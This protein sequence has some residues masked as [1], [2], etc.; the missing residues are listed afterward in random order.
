MQLS[1][2]TRHRKMNSA[3][4]LCY[5]RP[6]QWVNAVKS[7]GTLAIMAF[8][9]KVQWL[10]RHTISKV[11]CS[12]RHCTSYRDRAGVASFI[13]MKFIVITGNS[14]K[15]MSLSPQRIGNGCTFLSLKALSLSFWSMT[16]FPKAYFRSPPHFPFN[17]QLSG[18]VTSPLPG[19]H[20]LHWTHFTCGLAWP[21]KHLS[22]STT[23]LFLE[24]SF[25]LGFLWQHPLLNFLSLSPF[26]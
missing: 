22:L 5:L 15:H 7:I 16:R 19:F 21:W 8:Q 14:H 10:W 11:I 6:A 26:H 18:R 4:Q 20:P 2:Q 12:D 13:H 23:P 24:S 1:F 17:S 3:E 25:P 9:G